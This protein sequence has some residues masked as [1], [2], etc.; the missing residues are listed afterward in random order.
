MALKNFLNSKKILSM[1]SINRTHKEIV[2]GF[3]GE[4]YLN[5]MHHPYRVCYTFID[6]LNEPTL[7]DAIFS[8]CHNNIEL[9]IQL[10]SNLEPRTMKKIKRLTIDRNREKD[11]EYRKEFYDSIEEHS[12]ELMIFK[13]LDKLDN[14]LSWVLHDLEYYHIDVVLEEVCPRINRTN[15]KLARYL[16]KLVNF[17]I[18][19]KNKEIYKK[20][21]A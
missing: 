21:Y 7:E 3:S 17:T 9:G 19:S 11:K 1:N 6:Y 10:K 14:T 16:E 12:S 5:Y 20:A 4:P 13:G 8:L 15:Q 18:D 2:E